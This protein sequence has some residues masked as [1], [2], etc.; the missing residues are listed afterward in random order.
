MVEGCTVPVHWTQGALEV[1]VR[2]SVKVVVEES[3]GTKTVQVVVVEETTAEARAFAFDRLNATAATKVVGAEVV[4][5]EVLYSEV[6]EGVEER[7]H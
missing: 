2:D 6:G 4:E 7:N 1:G 5:E 3:L